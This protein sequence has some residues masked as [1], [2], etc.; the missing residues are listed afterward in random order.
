[1]ALGAAVVLLYVLA[2]QPLELAGDMPEYDSE[3]VFFTQGKPLWTT[4][5]FGV[6]HEGM[7]KAPIYP[8]WIGLLYELL[9]ASPVR[10]AIVQGAVL[11]PLGVLA[12]WA[13]GRRLFGPRSASAPRRCRR[14]SA[15]LG[16]LRPALPGGARGPGR[17]ALP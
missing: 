17:G 16:V 11:A 6:A 3:G 7:W 1:M 12:T 2:T 4:L 10:V 13:L 8:A 5:P 9:G 15:R 14:L